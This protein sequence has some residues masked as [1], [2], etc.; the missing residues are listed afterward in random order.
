M[1]GGR[2]PGWPGCGHMRILVAGD[3]CA[4]GYCRADRFANCCADLTMPRHGDEAFQLL[5]FT[6]NLAQ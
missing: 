4:N 5:H 2:F 6:V 3:K 1:V